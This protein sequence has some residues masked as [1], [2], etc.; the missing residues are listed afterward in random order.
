MSVGV[1][2]LVTVI[3]GAIALL[4][5]PAFGFVAFVPLTLLGAA[6][7]VL[8][9][10]SGTI[11]PGHLMLGL[12]AASCWG[13]LDWSAA[14]RD[15]AFPRAGFWLAAF[16]V[17]AV[18]GAAIL[19]RLLAQETFINAIGTTEYGPSVLLVPLGPT[20]GNVT[21]SIYIVAD[22]VCFVLC[23]A[24]AGRPDGFRLLARVM[25]VYCGLNIAFAALD[26][27]TFW[28]NTSYLLDPIRNADYQL[29]V[30]TL[31]TG[32]KRIVGSFTETSSFSYATLGALGYAAELWLAGIRP[33]LSGPIALVSFL[34]LVLSTSTTAY[35]ATP[36]LVAVLYVRTLIR[37]AHRRSPGTAYA[38]VLLAPLFLIAVTACILLTPRAM[39]AVSD[40]LSVLLFD[41]A[42]SQSGIE[43]AQ[44]NVTAWQNF[45]DTGGIGTGLGSVRA[46]SF[47]IALLANTGAPGFALLMVFLAYVLIGV[48]TAPMGSSATA[49]RDASRMACLGLF[50]GASV[51][52]AMVDLGLPFFIFAALACRRPAPVD[53]RRFAPSFPSVTG[54]R[55]SFGLPLPAAAR[56]GTP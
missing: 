48:R 19:P 38:F 33:R 24:F 56:E 46:S 2:G 40:T 32:L 43:R 21:Q 45:L 50:L 16:T 9:G 13:R 18:C 49:V 20:S 37:A 54:F 28:T 51:S 10:G 4:R 42:S 44:W 27:V 1:I 3:I 23:S 41:K 14:R 29:H 25:L 12:L 15:L 8:L 26:L 5:G 17:L 22:L 11:Q 34:L 36:V 31:V 52:G 39:A 53:A 55:R 47:P 6:G 30:E 7:A 35:V